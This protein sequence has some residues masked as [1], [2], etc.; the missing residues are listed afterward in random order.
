MSFVDEIREKQK[1]FKEAPIT[2][3]EIV[4]AVDKIKEYIKKL[5]DDPLNHHVTHATVYYESEVDSDLEPTGMCK[6]W[7]DDDR[8]NILFKMTAAHFQV[9]NDELYKLGLSRSGTY[10]RHDGHCHLSWWA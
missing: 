3:E 8:K 2:Q 5:T 9:V 1:Q 7:M 10:G 4:N 6:F